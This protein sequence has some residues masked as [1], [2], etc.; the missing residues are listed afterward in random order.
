[1]PL[2]QTTPDLLLQAVHPQA[3]P[4]AAAAL[5]QALLETEKATKRQRQPIEA[6]TLVGTWRLRFTAPQKPRLKDGQPTQRGFYIPQLIRAE[7]GFT[8]QDSPTPLAIHN[9]L[10]LGRSQIHF[11]GNARLANKNNILTFEFTHLRIS[12][13]GLNLYHGQISAAKLA[14]QGSSQFP[15]FVF[16]AA[17]DSYIAARGRGGGLALWQAT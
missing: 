5:T 12:I 2:S 16:F 10:T 9:Q 14:E 6:Q 3:D 7:I 11:S 8:P 17:T 15:F 1:M 4:P 13:A